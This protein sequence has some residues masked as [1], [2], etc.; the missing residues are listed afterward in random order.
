MKTP[1]TS[2][3]AMLSLVFVYLSFPA[4]GKESNK[5]LE[6][7][8]CIPI[9]IDLV[10]KMHV[11]RPKLNVKHGIG[12]VHNFLLCLDP[13]RTIFLQEEVDAIEKSSQSNMANIIKDVG[14]DGNLSYFRS[15][16]EKFNEK[17]LPRH[18]KMLQE[19]KK[20]PRRPQGDEFQEKD[21]YP[22]TLEEM[23]AKVS[24]M[25]GV[26]YM[27]YLEYLDEEEALEYLYMTA[28]KSS[29]MDPQKDIIKL[30]LRAYLSTLD[31]ASYYYDARETKNMHR[32][33]LG[34]SGIGVS[35]RGCPM[36]I[37]VLSVAPGGSAK[38]NIFVGEQ[39]VAVEGKPL[40]G[41]DVPDIVDLILGP[42]G[43]PVRVA[44]RGKDKG[45]DGNRSLRTITLNRKF[46]ASPDSAVVG[47]TFATPAGKMGVVAVTQFC[48]GVADELRSW[49]EANS[50][51]SGIILD[52]RDDLGGLKIE[53]VQMAGLFVDSAPIVGFKGGDG[54]VEWD[55]DDDSV[56][57][58]D[59]PTVVL[60][61]QHSA[62]ASEI[63][64]GALSD[65]GRAVVV[66]DRTSYGKG[67]VQIPIE[68]L[69]GVPGRIT[70]TIGKFF[71]P[72]GG[73]V[74]C[75]GVDPDILISATKKAGKTMKDEPFALQWEKIPPHVDMDKA[76][77]KGRKAALADAIAKIKGM[78]K[79]RRQEKLVTPEQQL[80]E[81]LEVLPELISVSAKGS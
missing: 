14:D 41:M 45:T 1:R 19:D 25:I 64:A 26:L 80:S 67:T 70:I 35:V 50:P 2:F 81:A 62:S 33:S 22:R 17:Q 21:E 37:H 66:G 7:E 6:Q 8:Y 46:I 4:L 53:A 59:G 77:T 9:I 5:V 30:V 52:L 47:E 71:R 79:D 24:R 23:E 31:A 27:S 55:V 78:G 60:V 74:H 13:G 20:H 28:D 68:H 39:I 76:P 12:M 40:A 10:E 15:L 43:T 38:G 49:V 34:Y 3:F 56:A 44:V 16:L 65:L 54:N 58:F 48:Y 63:V 18:L 11:S 29:P 42:D 69:P 72:S 73:S 61:N 57:T 75:R 32:S 51:M 36:G